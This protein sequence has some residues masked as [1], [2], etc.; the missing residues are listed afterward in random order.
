MLPYRK[1]CGNVGI[2]Q[3]RLRSIQFDCPRPAAPHFVRA[4]EA[5]APQV[6]GRLPGSASFASDRTAR[7]SSHIGRPAVCFLHACQ[8]ALHRFPPESMFCISNSPNLVAI[9]AQLVIPADP[10]CW[11]ARI[12][13]VSRLHVLAMRSQRNLEILALAFQWLDE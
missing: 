1:Q 7:A 9:N 6:G 13:G 2:G 11:A 12:T 8:H 10:L 5:A 3:R 4:P